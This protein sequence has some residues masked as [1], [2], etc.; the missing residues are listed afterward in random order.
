MSESLLFDISQQLRLLARRSVV[1]DSYGH[2]IN[3]AI[4]PVIE[5]LRQQLLSVLESIQ[6]GIQPP[7]HAAETLA[8]CQAIADLYRTEIRSLRRSC[9]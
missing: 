9:D 7:P 1:I 8:T 6:D 5:Q 4:N 3:G 2:R